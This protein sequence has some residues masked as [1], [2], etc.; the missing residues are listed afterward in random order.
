MSVACVGN[1]TKFGAD[2][3]G[4]TNGGILVWDGVAPVD[5]PGV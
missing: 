5:L 1:V 3:S 4:Y 2:N